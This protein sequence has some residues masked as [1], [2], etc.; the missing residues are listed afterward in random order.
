[1]CMDGAASPGPTLCMTTRD[2]SLDEENEIR[3]VLQE[4][5]S[6][7]CFDVVNGD[8]K[9]AAAT[10]YVFPTGMG[11]RRRKLIHYIV[12][13]E[14]PDQLRHWSVGKKNADKTVAIALKRRAEVFQ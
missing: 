7:C 13:T 6:H 2:W 5:I 10:T 4:Y 9:T 14:F 12:T 11:S 3:Q 8:T 1:M